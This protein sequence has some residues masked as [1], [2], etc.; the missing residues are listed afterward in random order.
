MYLDSLFRVTIPP[1]LNNLGVRQTGNGGE[2][3]VFS[4]HAEGIDLLVYEAPGSNHIAERHSLKKGKAGVWSTTSSKLIPGAE[5]SLQAWGPAGPQDSFS[6]EELLIDPY[7]KGLSKVGNQWRNVVVDTSFDWE[8]STK[9]QTPLDQSV[10]YEAHVRGLTKMHPGVPLELRGTYAGLGHEAMTTY[11][12]ELGVT[13]VE[14]LPVHTFVSEEHL[15]RQGLTNYWGYNTLNFFTPHEAYA[16]HESRAEGPSAVLREFKQMVKDL[17]AAGL[18]V[19]LDV[20]YN[21]TA[22]EGKF[23][24]RLSFRGLD[25]ASYYRQTPDGEYI[26]TTGCGTSLNASEPVVQKLILDSL[27]YWAEEVHVDGFRFDLAVTLGRNEDAEYEKDHPLLEAIRTDPV[28]STTK[29][30]AEPWD[31]GLDGWQTGNFADGWHEWNDRYRDR[32][33]NFWLPDIAQAR[34]TGIAPTGVGG[35]ATRLAGS[36]NTFSAERGP[37]ASVNFITAHDGFTLN[38]LT[39]YNYKHNIGNGEDN[40]DGTDNN[41]SFNHGVEGP[42][43]NP[44]VIAARRRTMRNLMGTL[45]LSAGIPMITAGDEFG[46]TQHGNNNAYCHDSPLTWVNWELQEWQQ[47]MLATTKHLTKMRQEH[48]ALRPTKFG[49]FGERIPSA[50]QVDWYNTQGEMMELE[51]WEDPHNRTLQYVAA[52]TPETGDFNRILMIIHGTEQPTSVVVPKHEGVLFYETL[53]FSSHHTPRDVPGVLRPG[54]TF[55]LTGTSIL[56]FNAANS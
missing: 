46:R 1:A 16:T 11:L 24:P 55:K 19:I 52:S 15:L 47:D 38:D 8:D 13:A 39:M 23:G 2:L 41:R 49:V 32:I 17:H 31:I 7:A 30:I 14:L 40:R 3:K 21:H 54:E 35:F 4:A 34:E 10:I 26:D 53:W 5:Y 37:V 18:E 22:E 45:L 33:R 43:D 25:N 50:S 12:T 48:P 51:D 36:S 9:P 56:L 6:V 28:L 42:T 44:D 20:V 29:L 27:R